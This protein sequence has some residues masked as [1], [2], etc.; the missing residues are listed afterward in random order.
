MDFNVVDEGCASEGEDRQ[1]YIGRIYDYPTS[2]DTR[3]RLDGIGEGDEWLI[4]TKTS[5]L[6]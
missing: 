4:S 6:S 3:N 1:K 2:K 5:R